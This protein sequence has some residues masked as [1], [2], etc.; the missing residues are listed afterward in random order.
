M[1]QVEWRESA[2]DSMQQIISAQPDR[3]AEFQQVLRSLTAVLRYAADTWGESRSGM[4]R[5][6]SIDDVSVLIEVDVLRRVAVIWDVRM[7]PSRDAG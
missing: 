6:G 7:N 2:F 4:D 3:I 1:F 5:L